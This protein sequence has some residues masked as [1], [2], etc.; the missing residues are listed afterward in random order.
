MLGHSLVTR[1]FLAAALAILPALVPTL[2][3]QTQPGTGCPPSVAITGPSVIP[4]AGGVF[5]WCYAPCGTLPSVLV[6]GLPPAVPV[7]IPNCGAL[8]PCII[9]VPVPGATVPVACT[10]AGCFTIPVPPL[11][12]GSQVCIHKACFNGCL[13]VSEAFV[14]NWC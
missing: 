4:A 9:C 11:P 13:V 6:I 14:I 8:V 2:S 1:T 10:A 12:H 5:T 7:T 3:A